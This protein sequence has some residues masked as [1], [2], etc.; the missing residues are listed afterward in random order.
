M[1]RCLLGSFLGL[2][3]GLASGC[4]SEM[5]LQPEWDEAEDST[6]TPVPIAGTL[7]FLDSEWTGE[8]REYFWR[9]IDLETGVVETRAQLG[10]FVRYEGDWP[11]AYPIRATESPDGARLAT[12]TDDCFGCSVFASALYISGMDAQSPVRLDQSGGTWGLQWSPDSR[13]LMVDNDWVGE[14]TSD[15]SLVGTPVCVSCQFPNYKTGLPVWGSNSETV[16]VL[17]P[18]DPTTPRPTA[19]QL[20][21]VDLRSPENPR[22]LTTDPISGGLVEPGGAHIVSREG[23]SYNLF[24]VSSGENRVFDLPANGGEDLRVRDMIWNRDGRYLLFRYLPEPG[25]GSEAQAV[26]VIDTEDPEL[27]WQPLPEV[28]P[29]VIPDDALISTFSVRQPDA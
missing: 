3:V 24:H 2:L 5:P 7:G 20:Y 26:G 11:R 16:L 10:A 17:A 21:E 1:R 18:T 29:F 12:V 9:H 13:R 25:E 27:R 8:R 15:D 22:Q 4:D 19:Y 23:T 14:I 28:L 6:Y